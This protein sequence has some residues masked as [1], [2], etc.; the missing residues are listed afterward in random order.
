MEIFQSQDLPTNRNRMIIKNDREAKRTSF[1]KS[2]AL[3]ATALNVIDNSVSAAQIMLLPMPVMTS[4][5]AA[6]QLVARFR[7]LCQI[8]IPAMRLDKY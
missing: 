3:V 7:T 4:R 6:H 1:G 8:S 5:F 2:K